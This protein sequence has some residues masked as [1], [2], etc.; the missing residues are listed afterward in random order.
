MCALVHHLMDATIGA[1]L[2]VS[3]LLVFLVCNGIKFLNFSVKDIF[4]SI[5]T[6]QLKVFCKNGVLRNF[7]KF[8]GKHMCQSLFF[9]KGAGLRPRTL[10]KRDSGTGVFLWFFAKLRN[11]YFTEHPRKT[12]SITLVFM[13]ST[14]FQTAQF[15]KSCFKYFPSGKNSFFKKKN[16]SCEIRMENG[17]FSSWQPSRHLHVQR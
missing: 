8:T 12:A 2:L 11:T 5:L 17:M 14:Q 15:L 9:N 7:T 1:V 4:K 10:S 6:Y 16:N 3:F 13:I